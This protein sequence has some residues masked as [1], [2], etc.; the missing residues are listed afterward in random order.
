MVAA[1]AVLAACG[2][3]ASVD[4]GDPG[5]APTGAVST[6]PPS[7]PTPSATAQPT[8]PDA[9]SNR[10]ALEFVAPGLDGG[11]VR[12]ADLAGGDVVLWMWAPW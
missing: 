12:G 2:G 8:G 7:S 4:D 3:P 6:P 9:T 5:A 11:R 1:A 10:A